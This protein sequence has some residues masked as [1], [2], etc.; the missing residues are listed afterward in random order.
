MARKYLNGKLSKEEAAAW[1]MKYQLR[2]QDRA[3]R[4]VRFVEQYRCYVVT[5]PVGEALVRE[6]LAKKGGNDVPKCWQ[7]FHRLL[8]TGLK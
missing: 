7:A 5:Y 4:Y 8:L 1:L 6:Y 2:S 3:E